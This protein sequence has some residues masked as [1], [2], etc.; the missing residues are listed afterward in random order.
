M[1]SAL[2][3]RAAFLACSYCCPALTRDPAA[4]PLQKSSLY[5]CDAMGYA[6]RGSGFQIHAW[7]L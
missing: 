2:L 3:A 7:L 1:P 6:S 4:P 5:L